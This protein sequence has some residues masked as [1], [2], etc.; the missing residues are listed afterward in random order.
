MGGQRKLVQAQVVKKLTALDTP[1][2]KKTVASMLMG[3]GKPAPDVLDKAEAT[4][5][6]ISALMSEGITSSYATTYVKVFDDAET[7]IET[8]R[9]LV[10]RFM[11]T[12]GLNE[13]QAKRMTD[14]IVYAAAKRPDSKTDAVEKIADIAAKAL[15][16]GV[17]YSVVADG[18]WYSPRTDTNS[19]DFAT[20]FGTTADSQG[21]P[22][23]ISRRA[24]ASEFA[25]LN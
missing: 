12:D 16:V 11:S 22:L 23:G 8:R 14:C 6:M 2:H 5:E 7:A 19:R 4:N 10:E 20:R 13:R 1:A 17:P 9:R 24:L 18:V 21:K 15:E 25:S 3:R